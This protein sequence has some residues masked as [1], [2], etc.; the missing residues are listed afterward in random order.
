MSVL[1]RYVGDAPRRMGDSAG[2]R[3]KV[4][5]VRLRGTAVAGRSRPA[6]RSG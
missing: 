2:I 3:F 5:T 1:S 4:I 6:S